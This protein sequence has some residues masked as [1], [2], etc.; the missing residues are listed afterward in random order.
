[1]KKQKSDVTKPRNSL[2]KIFRVINKVFFLNI[3]YA[4]VRL[5][6]K[7]LKIEDLK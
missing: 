3:N 7:L 1:M 5:I 6:H 4:S 2:H